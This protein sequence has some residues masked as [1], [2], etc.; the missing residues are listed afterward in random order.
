VCIENRIIFMRGTAALRMTVASAPVITGMDRSS[1]I[2]SGWSSF[3]FSMAS[4]PC[5]ASPQTSKEFGFRYTRLVD[6]E[7]WDCRRRSRGWA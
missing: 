2:K 6:S 4:L 3:A 7:C 5:S 1:K